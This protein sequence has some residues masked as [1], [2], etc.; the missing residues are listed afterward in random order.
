MN[1]EFE[2]TYAASLA[3]VWNA[4]TNSDEMKTWYFDLPGFK[5]E[6]GYQFHFFGGPS[7]EIQYKH[8]CEIT[9]VV[10][11]KKLT[12]S[13]KYYGYAGTSL[14]T[15]ELFPDND[16]TRLKL[17]HKGLET[18]PESVPDFERKN[19]VEGWTELLG[20]SLRKYLAIK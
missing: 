19:F 6:V 8:V 9:E 15:F 4:I 13:W 14:V 3:Q 12:Y 10:F 18:F 7:P 5:A 17:V 2:Y 20:T 11:Q 16:K 1:P